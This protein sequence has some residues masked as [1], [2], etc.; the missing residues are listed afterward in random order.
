MWPTHW[1]TVPREIAEAVDAAVSAAV[2]SNT[3]AFAVALEDLDGLPAEQVRL[4]LSTII[5]ELLE[6][7]H[8]DGL[9]GEDVQN[10][11]TLAVRRAHEWVPDVDVAS[12]VAVLTGA[13]GVADADESDPPAS[14]IP[15]AILLIAEL[16]SSTQKSVHDYVRRALDEVARAETIEMP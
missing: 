8:P 4:V 11:L 3:T 14:P 10:V 2:A 16:L 15:S 12:F 7:M 6:T 5:H 1:P 13:L 9:T